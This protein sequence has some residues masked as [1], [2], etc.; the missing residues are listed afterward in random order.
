[1]PV[2]GMSSQIGNGR[3]GE[4]SRECSRY[5]IPVMR[6]RN[7]HGFA[8]ETDSRES[9]SDSQAFLI[10]C[11]IARPCPRR[12]SFIRV[13]TVRVHEYSIS[14]PVMRIRNSHGFASQA[15]LRDPTPIRICPLANPSTQQYSGVGLKIPKKV[16]ELRVKDR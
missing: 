10:V 11:E 14:S 7:S 8:V 1:M 3:C 6:I 5:N 2:T 13:G 9:D 12:F 4:C 16:L 15:D